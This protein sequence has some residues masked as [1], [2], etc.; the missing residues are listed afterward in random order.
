[1]IFKSN[2]AHFD[3]SDFGSKGIYITPTV[4]DENNGIVNIR[5][6]LKIYNSSNDY[7]FKYNIFDK[8]GKLIKTTTTKLDN[9]NISL[10]NI[11]QWNGTV[12]PYLY[13]LES[14]IIRNQ[15]DS[16]VDKS[17]II[18][19]GFR[20]ISCNHTGFYL[21]GH[22]MKLNGVS[23]HQDR[24][25]K[26][27]AVSL[28]DEIEDIQLITE[29]GANAVRFAHYQQSQSMFVMKKDLLSGLKFLSFPCFSTR[30]ILTK[31]CTKY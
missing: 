17:D 11:I 21:N 7:S 30:L 9:I 14:L 18:K 15:D 12:N 28:S 3:L 5:S 29:V 2:E 8:N 24:L 10:D 20:Q 4:I 13:S 23:R 1:M 27:W 26:G 22:R 31:T 6:L 16:I 19:F 25:N